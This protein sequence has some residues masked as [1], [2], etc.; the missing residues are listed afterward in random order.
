MTSYERRHITII[1]V[2]APEEGRKEEVRRFY[3]QLRKEVY[4]YSKSDS[5]MISGDLNATVGNV[6]IPNELI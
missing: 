3:K 6:P 1:G 4:K 2:Y 5:L